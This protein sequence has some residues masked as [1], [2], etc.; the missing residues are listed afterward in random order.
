MQAI[1]ITKQGTPVADN[2][3]LDNDWP[4]PTPAAGEVVV[5]TEA[6]AFNHL[7]LWVGRGLPGLDLPFPRISGSD[8][9]GIVEAVG[10]GV[11]DAWVGRRVALNAAIPVHD[12]VHPDV[13][14][15]LPDNFMIGEHTHGTM[16]AK[17]AAPAANVI[18]IGDEADSVEAACFALSGLT[19]WRMLTTRARLQPGQWV[20]IPGIGGG[21]ALAALAIAKHLGCRAIVTSRHQHKLDKARELGAEVGI[22]DEGQDWSREARAAT[23][24]RGVDVCC[25]SVGKKIHLSCIKALARG[26]VFVTCGCTTGPD[27]TTDL[28]RIFWNQLTI[29]G[30]TMGD[31]AEFREVMALF[32]C[33]ALRPVIDNVYSPAD[34]AGAYA[35]LESGEQFGKIAIRWG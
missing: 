14:P 13:S 20:L 29:I 3:A 2:I 17:F 30:S 15:A 25:D 21:V 10:E 8:G 6:S 32:R 9:V 12:R 18:D 24:K 1:T 31:M 34:A 27:A 33:G 35:R 23:G 26:G 11:D 19:A 16:A 28:A 22:L 7:D 5:R 4:D